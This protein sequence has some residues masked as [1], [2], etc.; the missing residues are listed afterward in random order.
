MTNASEKH[1]LIRRAAEPPDLTGSWSAGAWAGAE[2]LRVDYFH[3]AS[4]DHR[5]E[6]EVKTLYGAR[7]L[8]VFFH[9][10]DRYVRAVT[11]HYGGPV[12]KDSC[13]EVFLQPRPGKGYFNFEF[14]CGGALLLY[15]IQDHRIVDGRFTRRTIVAEQDVRE[16]RIYHSLP[17][18]VEP[19]IQEPVEWM[20]EAAIPLSIFETYLGERID[21]AGERWRGNFFKCG[22]RT[23]HPH[24]ASWSPIGEELNFHRPEFFGV[25]EFEPPEI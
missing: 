4:T 9:V 12:C 13:V 24:W 25:L 21:P 10:R 22:D 11:G 3:P 2:T 16:L 1:I 23:S 19:E 7:H 20:L 14:N 17:P 6:T 8:Y 15:Y 18:I 5:P